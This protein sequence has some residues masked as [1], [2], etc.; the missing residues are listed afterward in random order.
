MDSELE[1]TVTI[2]MPVYNAASTI[3]AALESLLS[4][5]R[6]D[7]VLVISDNASS[8]A[9]EAICREYAGRDKRIH[10]LRQSTNVGGAMNFRAAL[11]EARTPYFMWAAGDDLWAPTFIEQA[12]AFLEAHP[13]YV[14]C[15]SRVLLTVNDRASHYSTGTYPLSGDWADN[16]VHFFYMKPD[17]CSRYYGMFRTKALQAV[18]PS[19][20]FHALDWAVCAATLKFGRHAELC[21]V[22]MIRDASP[23]PNYARQLRDEHRFFLWRMFPVLF[24]TLYCVRRHIVPVSLRSLGALARLNLSMAALIGSYG[25]VRIGLRFVASVARYVTGPKASQTSVS[26]TPPPV[27]RQAGRPNPALPIGGW[28]MPAPLAGKPTQLSIV[29]VASKSIDFTLALIDSIAKAHDNIAVEII[30]CDLDSGDIT[31]LL[32]GAA[33]NIRCIR[34]DA[35]LT[36]AAAANIGVKD[37]TAPIIGFFDQKALVEP[38]AIRKLLKGMTDS[39]GLIGSR[40]RYKDGRLC[41]PGDVN[42]DSLH[43]FGR[44][45]EQRWPIHMYARDVDSCPYAYLAPRELLVKLR[46]FD[47]AFATFDTAQADLAFRAR[48]AAIPVTIDLSTHRRSSNQGGNVDADGSSLS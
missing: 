40:A 29:I 13:D 39:I 23:V 4:Q 24:M 7:F 21:E 36:Y 37:A 28:R 47:E 2:G 5:T 25:L 48:R 11:F 8:D 26:P 41:P 35:S 15:Q 16:V 44:S 33:G 38:D 3:R 12:V 10:Y 6:P 14:C 17:D 19:R 27:T 1:P 42:R 34:C 45:D 46:G 32:W 9:T 30:I 22:L 18:F 20:T 31:P 43:D